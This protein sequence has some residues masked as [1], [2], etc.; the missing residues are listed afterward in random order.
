ME[1]KAQDQFPTVCTHSRSEDVGSTAMQTFWT[2]R[3]QMSLGVKSP[4]W[5]PTQCFLDT[6]RGEFN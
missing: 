1:L 4:I 2:D 6:L 3:V 5:H